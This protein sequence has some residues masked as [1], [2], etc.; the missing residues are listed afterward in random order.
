MDKTEFKK[1]LFDIS[2]AT[3]AC[4]GNIDEREI[5]ELKYIEKSTNYFKDIDLSNTLKRFIEKI[6]DNPKETIE[7]TINRLN[8]SILDP[9]EELL[10]LEITLRL[11]Y[12]DTKIDS[13]E[14]KYLQSIRSCLS[15]DDE[16]LVKRFG[17]IDFLFDAQ[18]PIPKLEEELLQKKDSPTSDELKNIEN[19]YYRPTDKKES[20]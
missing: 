2:C 13:E 18:K 9:V 12:A 1:L 3:V 7:N 10:V 8:S 11:I 15:I 5:R 17:V 14:V 4:D 19:M 20:K 16:T 6:K